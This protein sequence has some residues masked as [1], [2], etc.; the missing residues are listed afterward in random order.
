MNSDDTIDPGTISTFALTGG[1]NLSLRLGHGSAVVR[2]VDDLTE[3]TV[4]ITPHDG[5]DVLDRMTVEMSGPTLTVHAPRSGGLADL[6]APWRP[7]GKGGVDVVVTVPTGTAV[8]I[9]T[10]TASVTVKGRVGGADVASA[11]GSI[12]LDEIDGD[13]QLR[14]GNS[15][16]S[17][18]RVTGSVVVRSGSGRARFGEVL[19]DLVSGCG[20][21]RL[22]VGT[23]HGSVKSRSG[24]GEARLDAVHGD[25]DL[26]TGSGP[27]SI[28]LPAGVPVKVDVTTGSG[29]V[30]SDLPIEEEPA[31][32]T[33]AITVRV[34][35]GSG[36][37]RLF[38]AATAAA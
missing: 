15:D 9:A 20:S 34:R 3:A 35:T 14:Y 19:G 36:D 33:G 10:F 38:R 37:V 27:M 24:S 18:E 22:E 21:G 32:R 5:D 1:I 11:S 16:S 30:H 2:A 25:V 29:K 4:Q 7:Q 6:I 13:L 12:T 8:K 23:V 26:A 31:T 17:T 28:G